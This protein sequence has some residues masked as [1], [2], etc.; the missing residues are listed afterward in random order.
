MAIGD[1]AVVNRNVARQSRC[2]RNSPSTA[3]A[4]SSEAAR[5]RSREPRT[6]S[7]RSPTS[8]SC[9]SSNHPTASSMITSAAS[10]RSLN[11]HFHAISDKA[12]VSRTR[13]MSEPSSASPGCRPSISSRIRGTQSSATYE[14]GSEEALHAPPQAVGQADPRGPQ[15]FGAPHRFAVAE[16][17]TRPDVARVLSLRSSPRWSLDRPNSQFDRP[18]ECEDAGALYRC[19]TRK[20][21]P[22]D[23]H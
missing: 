23:H 12:S 19:G 17:A 1:P 6:Q 14:L 9:W 11:P 15:L 4:A 2:R 13:T 10:G 22:N 18:S 5:S 21:P 16:G 3:D 20:G 8:P 7:G